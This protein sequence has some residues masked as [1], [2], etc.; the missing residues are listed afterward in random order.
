PYASRFAGSLCASWRV[1]GFAGCGA[2]GGD[3]VGG[4]GFVGG[5]WAPQV[6]LDQAW[7]DVL[8]SFEEPGDFV[9]G[10]ELLRGRHPLVVAALGFG[11]ALVG[12]AGGMRKGQVAAGR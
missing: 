11:L 1:S 6:D 5:V 10:A 12:V 9:A 7:V 8:E 3:R 4:R 2:P